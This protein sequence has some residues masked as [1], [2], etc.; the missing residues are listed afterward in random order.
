MRPAMGWHAFSIWSL[1]NSADARLAP[2]TQDDSTRG[3]NVEVPEVMEDS[4]M[5]PQETP[6]YRAVDARRN[7]VLDT[8]VDCGSLASQVLA[9]ENRQQQAVDRA[10]VW[11]ATHAPRERTP[12]RWRCWFGAVLVRVGRRLQGAAPDMPVDV[13]PAVNRS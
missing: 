5:Y 3:T 8:I 6:H 2:P 9:A 12:S 13:A 7:R 11:A 4:L 1:R 10:A